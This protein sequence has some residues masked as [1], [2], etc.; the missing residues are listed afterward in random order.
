MAETAATTSLRIFSLIWPL[1]GGGG[2]PALLPPL[3]AARPATAGMAGA[4]TWMVSV[5]ISEAA[6]DWVVDDKRR[7]GDTVGFDCTG[8]DHRSR[9]SSCLK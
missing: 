2:R 9:H 8:Q 3:V 1:R 5:A 4:G 7:R 6:G